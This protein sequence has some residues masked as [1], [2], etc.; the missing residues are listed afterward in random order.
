MLN[1]RP[2]LNHTNRKLYNWVIYNNW[3]KWLVEYSKYYKGTLVDLGCGTAPYKDFF[4]QYASKYIGV[5]WT[6]TLHNSKADV[7]SNLNEKVE[8][9]DNCADTIVSLSVMEH[10]CEPQI[11]L[12]ESYRILKND[13]VMILQVP[14]MWWI[15]EAPY[16]Y[17]RYTPYGLKYMFEKAG[18]KDIHIQPMTGFFT[19]WFL[20]MNYFSLKWIKGSKLRKTLTKAILLP[21]WYTS[22]KLAPWLDNKHR[23][24]SLE[25]A[26]FFVVAKK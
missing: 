16:D 17:F 4:L 6:N 3:D 9:S 2:S 15:H 26:G 23:G 22:Q 12:N 11:F 25:S 8:I 5:D 10:L 20:K 13:G 7:I 24:W 14:W 21:F 19:M 18:Y 1:N